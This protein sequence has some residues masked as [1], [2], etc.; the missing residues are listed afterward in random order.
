MVSYAVRHW[1][2]VDG[3]DV[4]TDILLEAHSPE[5]AARATA[6]SF[7][8]K[9]TR[10]WGPT[11]DLNPPILFCLGCN[12][13][14]GPDTASVEVFYPDNLPPNWTGSTYAQPTP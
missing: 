2:E 12:S 9:V 7:G 13:A 14:E 10:L 5:E 8:D 11:L 3:K 6:A 4:A 1:H